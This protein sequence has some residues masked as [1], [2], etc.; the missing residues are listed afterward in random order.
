M[1][2]LFKIKFDIIFLNKSG[3]Q[4]KEGENI[5]DISVRDLSRPI[6]ETFNN[7]IIFKIFSGE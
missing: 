6:T 2:G 3:V 1:R 5:L 7:L 4:T